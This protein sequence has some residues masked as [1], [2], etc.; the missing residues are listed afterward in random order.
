MTDILDPISYTPIGVVRCD[1][2]HRFEMPR[3]GTL[4]QNDGVIEL[5]EG[6]N[7]EQALD[8]LHGFDRIWVIYDFHLNTTWKPKVQPPRGEPGKKRGVLA[9]RSP[10]RPNSIGMSCVELT[11]IEGRVLHIGNFDMLNGTPVLDIKP[12]IAYSDSFPDAE[13]A[14]LP[15]DDD[16]E[17]RCEFSERA[18]QQAL[19]IHEQSGLNVIEMATLQLS[20]D[21]LNRE[22][23]RLYHVGEEG[24]MQLGCRTWR[25]H[26][27]LDTHVVKVSQMSSSYTDAELCSADDRYG[28]KESH[29]QFLQ[30]FPRKTSSDN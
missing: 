7:L 28:D 27:T 1:A 21:P 20:R 13:T 30:H 8:D 23:K 11:G 26:F 4:A 3:Q 14:W 9:T 12:Y 15:A 17:Y 29:R 19:L 24:E 5:S 6:L 16:K 25:I 18:A 22:R 10:H 2:Q